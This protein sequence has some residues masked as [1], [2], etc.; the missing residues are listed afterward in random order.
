MLH[1]EAIGAMEPQMRVLTDAQLK[2]KTAELRERVASGAKGVEVMD[3]AFAVAREA[4]DRH[5]GIRNILNPR[6]SAQFDESKLS[7]EGRKLLEGVK[8]KLAT[9]EPAAP[10]GEFLG[11]TRTIEPWEFVEFPPALYE[12]VRAML[13]DSKPPFRSRPFDVQLIGAM[14][15]SQGKIAEMKTGEGKTIVASMSSPSTT[16]SSS[17]TA[18]GPSRSSAAWGSP[19]APSTP[20]TCRTSPRRPACTPAMWST[21]RPPSSASTTCAT[22]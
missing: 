12:A 7:S 18:T 14:V 22:T 13:P 19:S 16:T 3:E 21:A 6:F 8:A 17:A 15:L 9:M 11:N 4:M 2:Q 5:V 20:A 10:E 1:V